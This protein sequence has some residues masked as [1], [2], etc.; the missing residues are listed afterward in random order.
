MEAGVGEA[1]LQAGSVSASTGANYIRGKIDAPV[2]VLTEAE[3]KQVDE[4]LPLPLSI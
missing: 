2:G 4:Q 1:L 3:M